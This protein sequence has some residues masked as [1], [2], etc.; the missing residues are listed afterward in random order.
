MRFSGTLSVSGG[1][2]VHVEGEYPAG[3]TPGWMW[4]RGSGVI[5][6]QDDYTLT[7]D[8]GKSAS[9]IV[10]KVSQGAGMT[11]TAYFDWKGPTPS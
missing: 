11:P 9:V 10:S 3:A 8:N 5:S 7:L 2:A 4:A 1:A 6:P